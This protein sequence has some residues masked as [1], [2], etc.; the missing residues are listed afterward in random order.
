[1]PPIPSERFG[2]LF[3]GLDPDERVAFVAELWA[4]RGWQTT[5]DGTSV[6]VTRE[7]KSER[8][9]IVDPGRF[10]TPALEDIDVLVVARD[11]TAVRNAAADAG[12]RYL[13]PED[14]RELLLYG[15]ERSTAAFLFQRTFGQP[16]E[17][18]SETAPTRPERVRAVGTSLANAVSARGDRRHLIVLL[19]VGLLVGAAVGGPALTTQQDTTAVSPVE[20][21]TPG[22]PGAIGAGTATQT[23]TAAPELASDERPPGLGEQTLVDHVAL[24]DAHVEAV[25][26]TART[27]RMAATGPP[28]TPLLNGRE[29]WNVTARI[30]HPR[31]YRHDTTTQF[32]A[33][34][35]STSLT[36]RIYADGET[37]FRQAR[38]GT[39]TSY[40]RY[41][42][43]TTGDA[44]GF[45][46][47][48][49]E[50]LLQFLAGDD[51]T[52][53][54]VAT[55]AGNGDCF[56]YRVVVTGA[57]AAVHDDA[58]DYRAVAIVQDDGV[59]ASLDVRYTVP[60]DGERVPVRF[61]LAYDDIGETTVTP[62]TWLP[63]AKNETSG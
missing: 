6:V 61:Q 40:Q 26:G 45:A 33:A 7:A 15:L 28:D 58:S 37:K 43:E 44:S 25:G 56:A 48:V 60:V 32:P 10:G 57:P 27:L 16:L 62:P 50:Y 5:V 34:N 24:A 59:V 49:R 31:L 8:I 30:E 39:E 29:A 47:D 23:A 53:E 17:P 11:R 13:T 14:V 55:L 2:R 42:I 20:T 21:I 12:V 19:A 1:M 63:T 38:L 35:G 54:C 3:R 51:S 18:A 41:P 9:L 46:S 36:V 4:T 52:V 22:D